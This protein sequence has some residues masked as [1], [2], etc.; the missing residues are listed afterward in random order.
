[1]TKQEYEQELKLIKKQ[2]NVEFEIYPIA[3][4][5]IQPTIKGL[6]K[7]YVFSRRK[8]DRGQIYYGLS[9]FPDVAILDKDFKN[10]SNT[11][12]SIEDWQK[13]RGCLEVKAL[14]NKLI[15]KEDIEQ[16]LD[17]L[18]N[19]KPLSNAA[20]QLIGEILWYKRVVYTNG[21][22]WRFLYISEYSEDLCKT[23]IETVND[24]IK[25]QKN[26]KSYKFNWWEKIKECSFE[27]KDIV[28]S[29]NC[30]ENWDDF[31]EQVKNNI[32]W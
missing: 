26:E 14:R 6:S 21:I 10:T 16:A 25:K 24:R 11:N 20:G 2:N 1:M 7:R 13:L 3:L 18:K 15:T 31:I 12:I 27:I 30:M 17:D 19:S 4:E 32:K 9:S 5:I 8:T 29:K 28:I 22:E 23:I